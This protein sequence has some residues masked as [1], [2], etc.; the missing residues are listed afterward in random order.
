MR[1]GRMQPQVVIRSRYSV[2]L[3][4]TAHAAVAPTIPLTFLAVDV[5]VL[6]AIAKLPAHAAV[7]ALVS[8]F[9]IAAA[10]IDLHATGTNPE[11][12]REARSVENDQCAEGGRRNKNFAHGQFPFA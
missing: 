6:A 1:S 10:I 4:S 2:S 11:P 5:P 7:A 3:R 12:L 9:A 8:L